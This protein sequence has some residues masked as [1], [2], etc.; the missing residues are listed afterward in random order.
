MMMPYSNS[1]WLAS[2]SVI[3][4]AA[5]TPGA[6]AKCCPP[7]PRSDCAPHRRKR[8]CSIRFPTTPKTRRGSANL[9]IGRTPRWNPP[10][11]NPWP[12]RPSTDPV[13]NQRHCGVE[14][15]G[16][17]VVFGGCCDCHCRWYHTPIA[18]RSHL[19]RPLGRWRARIQKSAPNRRQGPCLEGRQCCDSSTTRIAGLVVVVVVAVVVVP[20]MVVAVVLRHH[21]RRRRRRRVASES[22][23]CHD[24]R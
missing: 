24:C 21:C 3:S 7:T 12:H 10:N 9:A 14:W 13:S 16:E 1:S 17:M 6:N 15:R 20:A 22:D 4:H 23:G 19:D 5:A 11:T 8:H 18:G 2:R